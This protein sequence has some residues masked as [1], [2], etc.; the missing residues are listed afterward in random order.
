MKIINCL[1]PSDNS[2]DLRTRL[3]LAEAFRLV[4]Q[5]YN[6]I[7][8]YDQSLENYKQAYEILLP[9]K[10]QSCLYRATFDIARS[11]ISA[12]K[13]PE[14]IETYLEMFNLV[15]SD[16]ERALVY[17]YLS[18]CYLNINNFDQAKKYAYESLDYASISNEDL[19]RIEAN[20]LLGKI[21]LKLKDVQRAEEYIIY[22]QN[23]KDQLGDLNQMKYLDDLLNDIKNHK[24]NISSFNQFEEEYFSKINE[25]W[26]SS[27]MQEDEKKEIKS[28]NKLI[29]Q[30]DKKN[31]YNCRILT[32]YHRLFDM[33]LDRKKKNRRNIDNVK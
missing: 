32:P 25:Q 1:Q 9:L 27:T 33:C 16:N 10:D 12:N 28:E 6:E 3:I 17:Q 29:E 20:I 24:E 7:K 14:A 22:A 26:I 13:Y 21:Y 31:I 23:L 5:S 30:L 18:F 8:S 2:L 4:G 15:T 11:L 19:L